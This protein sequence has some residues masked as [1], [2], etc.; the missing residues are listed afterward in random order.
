MD[1]GSFYVI[2][3]LPQFKFFFKSSG[4]KFRMVRQLYENFR[5]HSS[6]CLAVLSSTALTMSWP[7]MAAQTP[8]SQLHFSHREG[9]KNKETAGGKALK[10][11][12]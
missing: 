6:F 12:R 9:E 10:N 3:I 11:D 7:K 4:G 2:I 8:I 5:E 1:N